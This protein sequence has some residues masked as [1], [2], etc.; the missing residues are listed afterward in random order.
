MTH[1]CLGAPGTTM[2]HALPSLAT[3][4]AWSL[5][6]KC[7]IVDG[8]L[9]TLKWLYYRYCWATLDLSLGGCLLL[10][11]NLTCLDWYSLW[12][13]RWHHGPEFVYF[14]SEGWSLPSCI[15]ETIVTASHCTIK[16]ERVGDWAKS[17]D[18]RNGPGC[19]KQTWRPMG[20]HLSRRAQELRGSDHC[21]PKSLPGRWP[22]EF[23]DRGWK[24]TM[25]LVSPCPVSC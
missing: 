4:K 19:D 8:P 25:F 24:M 5:M 11:H 6:L 18:V 22:E 15:A 21:N 16:E 9:G 10:Q 17:Q 14:A 12:W 7:G 2:L 23:Q 3:K 1:F 13:T 20:C